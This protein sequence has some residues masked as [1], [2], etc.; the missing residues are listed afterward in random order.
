MGHNYNSK[1]MDDKTEEK[2]VLT[3][4]YIEDGQIK[5]I[6]QLYS[7]LTKKVVAE[8]LDLNKSSFSNKKSN[9]PGEFKLSQLIK[10]A[11]ALDVDVMV[12]I[13]IFINS[14]SL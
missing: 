8:L 7:A 13:G 5:T 2:I 10:L 3:R 1:L 12:L 11:Q 6:A 14:I 4:S 9:S